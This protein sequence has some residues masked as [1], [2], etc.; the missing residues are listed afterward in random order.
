MFSPLLSAA[1][2]GVA[3][4]DRHSDR[5]KMLARA[6]ERAVETKKR[7]LVVRTPADMRALATT[8]P[9]SA[10]VMADCAIECCGDRADLDACLDELRRVTG[11]PADLFVLSIQWWA[12][13]RIA[14]DPRVRWVVTKA[15]PTSNDV[16]VKP[17]GR[18]RTVLADVRGRRLALPNGGR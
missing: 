3:L 8:A 15:P 14:L 10:V 4:L 16:A 13:A 17:Y 11:R 12:G 1:V 6:E 9:D 7:L 2:E 18:R 5:G